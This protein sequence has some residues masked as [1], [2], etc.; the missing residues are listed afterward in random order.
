MKKNLFLLMAML[1]ILAVASC[2]P[3]SSS[4]IAESSSIQSNA[5]SQEG[6]ATPSASAN[7]NAQLN[8]TVKVGGR[9]DQNDFTKSEVEKFL[10]SNGYSNVKVEMVDLTDSKTDAVT[11]WKNG[12]EVYSLPSD[13]L[14]SLYA[15][16]AV[17]K[18]PSSYATGLKANLDDFYYSF[19][20]LGEDLYSYP[21]VGDNGYILYY[22]KDIVSDE[23]AKTVEGIIAACKAKGV[24]FEYGIETAF[25]FVGGLQSFGAS[26][27]VNLNDDNTAFASVSA[28]FNTEKGLKAVKALKALVNDPNV[29]TSK[30]LTAPTLDNGFG[31]V[32]DG[33]WDIAKFEAAVGKDKLG[34]TKLPT[35]TLDGETQNLK[36]FLGTKNMAVNPQVAGTDTKRLALDHAIA[37]YLVSPEVQKDRFDQF[38]ITPTDTNTRDSVKS[39]QYVNAFIEQK[40]YSVAQTVVPDTLW[41]TD[42]IY[43]ALTANPNITDQEIATL[44]DS[45]NQTLTTINK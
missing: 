41:K 8:Y 17:A 15:K 22:N 12:P 3:V 19:G 42:N 45:Y 2:S 5:T 44:L 9:A 7:D 29:S 25:Y 35:I 14:L 23:Q 27:K 39:N 13:K 26:Y 4:S 36:S 11:D 40:P 30:T 43:A 1:P 34:A 20:Q 28:D 10:S 18:V 38:M 37:N 21:Y 16:G 31:A 6:S 24:K 33:S 32:I